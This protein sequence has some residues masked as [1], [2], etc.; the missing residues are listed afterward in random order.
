[1][2]AHQSKR[3]ARKRPVL[4]PRQGNNSSFAKTCSEFQLISPLSD[5]SNPSYSAFHPKHANAHTSVKR[6][7]GRTFI[8]ENVPPPDKISKHRTHVLSNHHE[9]ASAVEEQH[10]RPIQQKKK[11]RVNAIFS[12]K[13]GT[14]ILSKVLRVQTQKAVK[15]TGKT[16]KHAV[17]KHVIPK[18]KEPPF[19][20]DTSLVRIQNPS[21]EATR[22]MTAP[23]LQD[24]VVDASAHNDTTLGPL[25]TSKDSYFETLWRDKRAGDISSYLLNGSLEQ[26]PTI[27]LDKV[28]ADALGSMHCEEDYFQR[29]AEHDEEESP[30]VQLSRMESLASVEE[31]DETCVSYLISEGSTSVALSKTG[32]ILQQRVSSEPNN[33]DPPGDDLTMNDDSIFVLRKEPTND[34]SKRNS[35]AS[36]NLVYS[37]ET[38]EDASITSA[39]LYTG[40]T[41]T[42][43]Y[44]VGSAAPSATGT[45]VSERE[46]RYSSNE[47]M[48]PV[49][50]LG[51]LV[52]LG[53]DKYSPDREGNSP[54][55]S[56]CTKSTVPSRDHE[57]PYENETSNK[58]PGHVRMASL[59]SYSSLP[60]EQDTLAVPF[61]EEGVS[62]ITEQS[63]SK[64]QYE[65]NASSPEASPAK[66][67][68]SAVYSCSDGSNI[69]TDDDDI[70]SVVSESTLAGQET[71]N[72][73]EASE[74]IVAIHKLSECNNERY[75]SE[76]TLVESPS[77]SSGSEMPATRLN[78]PDQSTAEV[79][80]QTA[81]ESGPAQE[82]VVLEMVREDTE[83]AVVESTGPDKEESKDKEEKQVVKTAV[84]TGRVFA[85]RGPGGLL[86]SVNL[87][88]LNTADEKSVDSEIAALVDE[89]S[90]QEEEAEEES[91]PKEE[92]PVI[93]LVANP[94]ALLSE[95][96]S[97]ETCDV[98]P[99]K[100]HEESVLMDNKSM[101]VIEAVQEEVACSNAPEGVLTSVHD[102]L[103]DNDAT[104]SISSI[105]SKSTVK[106]SEEAD[107][108][109]TKIE[110]KVDGFA[111][112]IKTLRSTKPSPQPTVETIASH[113]EVQEPSLVL[114]SPPK[115]YRNT[116]T[117][118][119]D[120][121]EKKVTGPVVNLLAAS[122]T[123][124][125]VTSSVDGSPMPLVSEQA[126][127][128][129][130]F[131]FSPSYAN[132]RARLL[133]QA[134][135]PR[136]MHLST[137]AISTAQSRNRLSSFSARSRPGITIPI[138]RAP[139]NMSSIRFSKSSYSY[140]GYNFSHG[141]I[142]QHSSGE[143]QITIDTSRFSRDGSE[144]HVHFS[145][146]NELRV[147]RDFDTSRVA[148]GTPVTVVSPP[149]IDRKISDLT[150]ATLPIKSSSEG[151]APPSPRRVANI[152]QEIEEDGDT[153]D[154]ADMS[155]HL[156]RV[157]DE[158][159]EDDNSVEEAEMSWTY[160]EENGVLCAATPLRFNGKKG[161]QL[162][163]TNSPMLRFQEA[164]NKFSA[165]AESK[166]PVRKSTSPTV[167]H[168]R[169]SGGSIGS[170]KS[171]VSELNDRLK[172]KRQ[173][174]WKNP[175]RE[176]GGKNAL[177]PRQATL[178]AS[179]FKNSVMAP[180]QD[181]A[182]L[183]AT[184]GKESL[185][186]HGYTVVSEETKSTTGVSTLVSKDLMSDTGVST[187]V[188][189]DVSAAASDEED[190]IFLQMVGS[191]PSPPPEE[192]TFYGEEET[193]E[194]EDEDDAFA[195]M[196]RVSDEHPSLAV[197]KLRV[198]SAGTSLQSLLARDQQAKKQNE[199][200]LKP[201][202]GPLGSSLRSIVSEDPSAL[203]YE[204]EKE[205]SRVPSLDI[206]TFKEKATVNP[207]KQWQHAP[208][209][210]LCL[211]PSRRTPIQAKK[212]RSL[213]AQ[214]QESDRAKK[215][216]AKKRSLL[217]ERSSNIMVG[218]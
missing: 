19:A 136:E 123:D 12:N 175:R 155:Y 76:S 137:F 187:V 154:E 122:P 216:S 10:R 196:R 97:N 83:S 74:V 214:A 197:N 140:E 90:E 212:W 144:K 160:R 78:F 120:R 69:T 150:E 95:E 162:A 192:T 215:G 94:K 60:T 104:S 199:T 182:K 208:P 93:N 107:L 3:R 1:M 52:S 61:V 98:S 62:A 124:D 119:D 171:R 161:S 177:A 203:T 205:N 26:T 67:N 36:S 153:V 164:R 159:D 33:S 71:K 204:T 152:L 85:P 96:K 92:L 44:Q 168:T 86:I 46:S 193:E 134:D 22:A 39:S 211:S 56:E 70:E 75:G 191:P 54:E 173:P 27:A 6:K 178:E 31:Q 91:E 180:Y 51:E 28:F 20:A 189:A 142:T 185:E 106:F 141:G 184:N 81:D 47:D 126:L 16:V 174:V 148:L 38:A 200:F 146:A 17:A 158:D 116:A 9:A 49:Q 127:A 23:P 113:E 45:P 4:P 58:E 118:K 114:A 165:K 145:K 66:E 88:T 80:Q 179:L 87:S 139:V 133:K 15:Q 151:S 102:D 59:A 115:D 18:P 8:L 77:P 128:N 105:K 5:L 32:T 132:G 201:P 2:M 117:M 172:S 188:S 64:I 186:S 79:T 111:S 40:N 29:L 112:N 195:D 53:S 99:K 213:A 207:L 143:S 13:T 110:H 190:D 42:K 43:A 63:I 163:P 24:V 181:E 30:R 217:K 138:N 101:M 166:A 34:E 103:V 194:S 210:D 129:A 125:S 37:P 176:T 206:K 11:N 50:L 121:N 202:M 169:P 89:S 156:G 130:A 35:R 25:D 147:I 68:L 157:Q 183:K 7:D 84:A 57:S 14:R 167:E 55:M 218:N 73:D 131:L 209:G 135:P 198:S 108:A 149:S 21:H 100:M 41:K 48:S 109:M 170:V 82:T 65:E 72:A